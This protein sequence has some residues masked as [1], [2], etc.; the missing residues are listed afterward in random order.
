MGRAIA[1]SPIAGL[2]IARQTQERDHT[3]MSNVRRWQILIACHSMR[4][5]QSQR[6]PPQTTV[7]D[8][9]RNRR[10]GHRPPIHHRCLGDLP[11]PALHPPS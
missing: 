9:N 2:A 5:A 8:A 3:L 10:H 11:A 1:A 4:I 6:K 7:S